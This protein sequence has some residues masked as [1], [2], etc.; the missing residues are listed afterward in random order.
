MRK[1]IGG[2]AGLGVGLRRLG[3]G[4]LRWLVTFFCLASP[5]GCAPTV[6]VGGVYFPGWLVA[7]IG[8]VVASYGIVLWLARRP[9]TRKLA[10]SGLFFLSLVAGVALA[11]WWVSFSSF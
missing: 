2:D 6:D 4:A 1:R 11:I 9:D 7:A 8:G 3:D 5:A 10:D